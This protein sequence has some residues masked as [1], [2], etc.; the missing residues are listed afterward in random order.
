MRRRNH[1]RTCGCTMASSSLRACGS[2]NTRS[3]I[4]RRSSEPS[5]F[6]TSDPNTNSIC[7]SAGAPGFTTAR[8]AT[9]ASC[10]LTP[11]DSNRCATS[12]L[13]AAT[14]PVKAT[15]YMDGL[16]SICRAMQ[17]SIRTW[18]G[19]GGKHDLA[20]P[21][22]H[23]FVVIGLP[24]GVDD[25]GPV[26]PLRAEQTPCL[27]VPRKSH[28]RH[29]YQRFECVRAERALVGIRAQ[30]GDT[31]REYLGESIGVPEK[32][33]HLEFI[34]RADAVPR[35]VAGRR[36]QS[37]AMIGKEPHRRDGLAVTQHPNDSGQHVIGVQDGVVVA[38]VHPL[39]IGSMGAVFRQNGAEAAIT[40]RVTEVIA[41]VAAH[42]VQHDEEI[43]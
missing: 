33:R 12:L 37:F 16:E 38:V 15:T 11:R 30:I 2:A 43:L 40:L 7:V 31:G 22:E 24:N 23:R 1:S 21:P 25:A 5:A 4:A 13:P 19:V 8:A 20:V 14:P 35:L 32:R 6:K 28:A 27:V 9:S 36:R 42:H 18:R 39:A 10:T 41:Q 29:V 26:M 34:S 3:R 17:I